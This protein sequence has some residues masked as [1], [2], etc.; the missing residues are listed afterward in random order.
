MHLELSTTRWWILFENGR[1][2]EFSYFGCMSA[3]QKLYLFPLLFRD[4]HACCYDGFSIRYLR[5]WHQALLKISV[6]D[7]T[8]KRINQINYVERRRAVWPSNVSISPL[9]VTPTSLQ[10]FTLFRQM[11]REWDEGTYVIISSI[12]VSPSTKPSTM[13][14]LQSLERSRPSIQ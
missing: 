13:N 1:M 6:L 3:T 2:G 4:F 14:L 7:C 8:A 10:S 5:I 11:W 12:N 9:K